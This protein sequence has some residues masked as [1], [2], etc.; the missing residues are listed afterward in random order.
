MN[1]GPWAYIGSAFNSLNI[2]LAPFAKF[3]VSDNSI[4]K[5]FFFLEKDL[6]CFVCVFLFCLCFCFTK[7]SHFVT[8]AV[9]PQTHSVDLVFLKHTETFL[10]LPPEY[11]D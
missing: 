7:G 9:C 4:L 8:L 10:P 6:F 3:Y 1:S 11:Q 2:L 5:F